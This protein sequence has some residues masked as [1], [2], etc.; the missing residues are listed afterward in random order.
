MTP[1]DILDLLRLAVWT[2]SVTAAPALVAAMIT[3]LGIAILQALTQIQEATLSFVP[4]IIAIGLSL[5]VSSYFI[6]STIRYFAEQC[7]ERIA[8]PSR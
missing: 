7:Y 3:G 5:I 2:L 4:K 6:G 8:V 1:A